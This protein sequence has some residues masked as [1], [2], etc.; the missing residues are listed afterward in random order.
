MMMKSV[1]EERSGLFSDFSTTEA[2]FTRSK[3][4]IQG[5]KICLSAIGGN[6]I[7]SKVK[8]LDRSSLKWGHKSHLWSNYICLPEEETELF[9]D[10]KNMTGL[11][12][13]LSG[14]E[15]TW[16]CRRHRFDPWSGKIP[17]VSGQVSPWATTTEPVLW[18]LGPATTESTCP[19]ASAPQ[20]EK[21]LQQEALAPEAENSPLSLQLA[22]SCTASKPQHNQQ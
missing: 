18:S 22:K 14:K 13:W 11:P 7:E 17:Y 1:S 8:A 10:I 5:D 21:L 2:I 16:Q 4:V 19:R 3:T 15:P 9:L 12:W 20:Q 6:Q